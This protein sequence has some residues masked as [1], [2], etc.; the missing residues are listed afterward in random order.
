M[1]AWQ[2]L[3]VG[4]LLLAGATAAP[5]ADLRPFTADYAVKYATMSVG[6]S[7]LELRRDALPG[8]WIVE[9]RADASGFARLLASGTLV[10]T[11]WLAVENDRVRPL[12]FRFDDGME[13]ATEDVTLD[14]DWAAGR[15]TG[16]S[17]G[18]PVDVATVPDLQDPVSLQV[19]VMAALQNG[20]QPGRQPML[21]GRKIKTYDYLLLRRERVKTPAGSF[22]TVVY[23]SSR[24]GSD[25]VTH[26]WLAPSLGYL[27]VQVEQYRKERRLFAMYLQKYH[28]PD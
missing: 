12:R 4:A 7:R 21:E 19:A 11:S 27:A 5:A 13:R 6:A 14:F 18:E 22:D 15:V 25:R 3:A 10:Q 17:K 16:S 24:A 20:R 8:R 2:A 9:S 26:M 28:L 23:T 1:K